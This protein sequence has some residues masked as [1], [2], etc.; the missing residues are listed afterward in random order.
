MT[1]KI[2]IKCG[3]GISETPNELINRMIFDINE[4]LLSTSCTIYHFERQSNDYLC[5]HMNV[6]E[7]IGD[8]R[9]V[10]IGGVLTGYLTAKGVEVIW[11]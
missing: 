2:H 10:W 9:N 11:S 7:A 4:I 3:W 1:T 6:S 8:S 5:F